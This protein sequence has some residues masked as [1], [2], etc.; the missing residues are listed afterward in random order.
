MSMCDTGESILADLNQVEA[1]I[2]NLQKE[3]EALKAQ[4][5][6]KD[7]TIAYLRAKTKGRKVTRDEWESGRA[8][9]SDGDEYERS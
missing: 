1:N 8:P 5:K 4:L 2:V 3:I 7:E 9:G 6:A